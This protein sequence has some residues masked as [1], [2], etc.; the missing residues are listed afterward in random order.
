MI[1]MS[2]N[3]LNF[4]DVHISAKE[5]YAQFFSLTPTRIKPTKDKVKVNKYQPEGNYSETITIHDFVAQDIGQCSPYLTDAIFN[6]I[7][8]SIDFR[9]SSK[10]AIDDYDAQVEFWRK[11]LI[12]HTYPFD[13]KGIQY[14]PRQARG[15]G[16]NNTIIEPT[17]GG[18]EDVE[19]TPAYNQTFYI[20]HEQ[21]KYAN[22][23][24]LHYGFIRV[25]GKRKDQGA[26][27]DYKEWSARIEVRLNKEGCAYVGLRN[28]R[29]L[30]NFNFRKAFSPYFRMTSPKVKN[31]DKLGHENLLHQRRRKIYFD[32]I[33]HLGAYVL[34]KKPL[35]IINRLTRHR[36]ANERIGD[37]LK[38]LS[39]LFK[40]GKGSS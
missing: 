13:A 40:T 26:S 32:W 4:S 19:D 23:A 28:I 22:P 20:G 34:L 25:Y 3:H 6:E 29:D 7:E 10:L 38:N 16:K 12:L 39:K 14:A 37:A 15:D 11:W 5:D 24:Q 1:K 30:E 9:P 35:A 27:L 18:N 33:E 36:V 17:F 21:Y 8:M 2:A 31:N